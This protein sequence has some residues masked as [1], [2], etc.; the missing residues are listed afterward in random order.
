M[1]VPQDIISRF[2]DAAGD[3]HSVADELLHQYPDLKSARWV[4]DSILRFLAI[5]NFPVGV[6]YLVERGWPL[7][8]TNECGATPLHDA[9]RAHAPDAALA[10]LELG[11]NPNAHSEIYD[12][13]IHCAIASGDAAIV[14]ALINSGANPKYTTELG[15]TAFDVLPGVRDSANEIMAILIASGMAPPDS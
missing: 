8:E 3:D 2:V 7:D 6:K 4:G 11:A 9:I 5:E 14:R 13:P 15:E 10:L 1:T 12:K